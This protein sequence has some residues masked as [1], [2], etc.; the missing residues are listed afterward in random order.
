MSTGHTFKI[1]RLV[2]HRRFIFFQPVLFLSSSTMDNASATDQITNICE[3]LRNVQALLHTE[4]R[5]RNVWQDATFQGLQIVPILGQVLAMPRPRL[6]EPDTL[7]IGLEL[8]RLATVLYI[9]AL[10]TP[11]GVDTL[12]AE[13]LYASKIQ[14]ILISLSTIE[15]IPPTML[16]WV[17]SVAFTSNCESDVKNYFEARLVELIVVLGITGFKNLVELIT[18]FIWDE[19][20]LASQT[21]SLCTLLNSQ[22]EG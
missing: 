9:S 22:I 18:S 1:N 6:D 14:S 17:L 16:V 5:S 20:L 8:F 19:N 21:F 3:A 12:S 7:N 4:I 11:F 13:P 10:R 2:S 15:D